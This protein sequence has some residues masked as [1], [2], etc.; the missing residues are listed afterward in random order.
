MLT[1]SAGARQAID[2]A[3]GLLPPGQQGVW[4]DWAQSNTATRLPAS[5]PDVAPDV[6]G[7]V[8]EV[9][10]AALDAQKDA[11]QRAL[12]APDVSED[13]I[14]DLDNDLSHLCAIERDVRSVVMASV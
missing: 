8:A 9:V 14:S 3:V 2:S 13:E 1:L 4:S 12:R 11:Y 6:P 5:M 10:L 7:H